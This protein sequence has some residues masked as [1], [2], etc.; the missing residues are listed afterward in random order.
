MSVFAYAGAGLELDFY[1]AS[2][3]V[4]ELELDL[5]I[6]PRLQADQ[7][8]CWVLDGMLVVDLE[9]ELTFI[10]WE[11]AEVQTTLVSLATPLVYAQKCLLLEVTRYGNHLVAT[12]YAQAALSSP[13]GNLWDARTD[14]KEISDLEAKAGVV[15]LETGVTITLSD[16]LS[17]TSSNGSV[18]YEAMTNS[19]GIPS[20]ITGTVTFDTA[21]SYNPNQVADSTVNG[22]ARGRYGASLA[23]HV[24]G[25]FIINYSS[26]VERSD[27]GDHI[28]GYIEWYSSS[29]G[30]QRFDIPINGSGV[31]TVSV[32]AY[33]DNAISFLPVG[34]YY[35]SGS[36]GS[37]TA[38]TTFTWT[39][40]PAGSP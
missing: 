28:D 34:V 4:P 13:D 15:T 3:L 27:A 29:I 18:T 11:L 17:Q 12:S 36:W 20:I 23:P 9:A 38:H 7:S 39:F 19:L 30:V 14:Y 21:W 6:G 16:L 35:S 8:L 1:S 5:R 10:K 22:E 25:D 33:S 26:D 24:D 37:G 31:Y 2:P 32:T 40:V